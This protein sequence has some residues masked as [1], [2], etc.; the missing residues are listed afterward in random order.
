LKFSNEFFLPI[1]EQIKE[2]FNKAKKTELGKILKRLYFFGSYSKAVSECGD[3]DVLFTYSKT[4]L[5]EAISLEI[6]RLRMDECEIWS[7]KSC[8]DYPDCL[9]C[10]NDAKCKL[11]SKDYQSKVH[12]YCMEKC[13]NPKKEPL[14]ECLEYDCT[15]LD[16]EIEIALLNNLGDM[17][18]EDV[19]QY[20]DKEGLK[21]KVLD[22]GASSSI[23]EFKEL[24][25]LIDF[26]PIR[27]L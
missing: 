25:H 5:R 9:S 7:F 16:Y 3:I 24:R 27:I 15:L 26:E 1:A 19:K 21:I 11:P 8:Q 10:Y 22:L 2:N 6:K 13:K 4:K 18:K 14:P 17:L 20:E 23:K 12:S